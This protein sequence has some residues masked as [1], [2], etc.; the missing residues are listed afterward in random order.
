MRY[1]TMARLMVAALAP[2]ANVA[3][4]TAHAS[5]T[6]IQH[7]VVLY[8]ENHSFDNVLGGWCNQTGRCQGMP[9]TVKLKSGVV[10]TPT[11]ASDVVPNVNHS[12]AG[13]LAAID[14]G[15]MDGWAQ[16]Q[17]CAAN[18]GYVC[19][20]GYTPAQIPNLTALASKF[21]V[22]NATFSMADSPSWGGHV[23]A[24][25]ATL[26]NFNGNNPVPPSPKPASWTQGPGWGCNSN[27]VT[28]WVD[29]LTH[30][31]SQQPSCIPDPA[32]ARPNGGAFEPTAAQYVPTIMDEAAAAGLSWRIYAPSQSAIRGTCPSFAECEYTAQLG[33][34][35]STGRVITDASGGTLP[36]FSLVIP[37][38]IH[39]QHNGN[40]MLTG[41]NWIGQVVSA[42]EKGP[43]WRSTA[44]FITYDDCGC[45]YDSVAP[46]INPDGTQQGI[47]MPVVLVSPYT[48]AG[49]VDSTPTTIAG[50]LAYVEQNFG[51]RPLTANDAG[52]YAFANAFDYSQTPIAGPLMVTSPIPAGETITNVPDVT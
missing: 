28:T 17:G 2:F 9:A 38:A 49:F 27:L 29:P 6:P 10:V 30:V 50:I 45:F 51:L 19:I 26:D 8:M 13:Q 23:Y 48:K 24:V 7:V 39:S 40:S 1:K 37:D 43:E 47:R 36:A 25:A 15:A 34:D 52:A 31:A 22:S 14:G 32:L 12:V 3:S 46:G 20:S 18:T 4:L 11:V 16:V 5:T 41:D 42:I 21:A 35:I 44:V 33:N